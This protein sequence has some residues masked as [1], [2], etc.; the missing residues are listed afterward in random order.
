MDERSADGLVRAIKAGNT[1]TKPS[2]LHFA[3][4]SGKLVFGPDFNYSSLRASRR[5][6]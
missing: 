6:Y 4:D 3:K 2:A 1:R 5:L